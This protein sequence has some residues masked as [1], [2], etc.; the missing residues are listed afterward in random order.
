MAPISQQQVEEILKL[1][2]AKKAI[3]V[4]LGEVEENQSAKI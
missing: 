3:E 4:Y 1:I 2:A